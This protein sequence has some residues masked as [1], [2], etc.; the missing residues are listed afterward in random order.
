MATKLPLVIKDFTGFIDGV[1]M[2]GRLQEGKLPKIALVTE[3][4]TAAGMGGT[5]DLGMGLLEKL[6]AELTM[7]GL[8]SDFSKKLGDP[9]GALTLRGAISDGFTTEAA[10]FQMR[11]LFKEAEFG[12]MK[13]K[14]KGTTK[15]MVTLTYFKA[16]ISGVEITEVDVINK[17]WRVHG[18]DRFAEQSAALGA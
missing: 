13:R 17:I 9:D 16:T 14:D 15:L 10:V 7:D 8:S 6:E 5:V 12:N 4:H 11:G 1:G 3:E 18:V 2:A